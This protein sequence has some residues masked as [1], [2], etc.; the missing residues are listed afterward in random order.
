MAELLIMSGVTPH[1]QERLK[2][3][4]D[5]AFFADISPEIWLAET[6]SQVRFILT[7][8]P[9]GV[10]AD[11]LASLPNAEIISNVGVGYDGVDTAVATGRGIPVCHTPNVL[12]EEVA[13]TALMLYLACWRNFEAEMAH[14]RSGRW[15]ALGNLPLP[16]TADARTVGILGLG[17]IGKAIVAKLAPWSPEILYFGRSKQDVP[18][19]YF[20]DLTEMARACDT[21]INI[22]PGGAATQHLIN[23]EVMDAVGPAGN[24][25]NVGRGSTVDE[26]AL[27]A[28]LR[29]GSLGGAGLDVYE[30]EP[31][32]PQ[33]LRNASNVVLLPH[34]ASASIETRRAMGDLAVDNLIAWKKGE[35]LISPVPESASLI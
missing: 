29:E 28:A 2:A 35:A 26:T 23:R 8:G 30:S 17:R 19:R 11:V 13:T 31:F 4:F 25:I 7:D 24:L 6:G 5:L 16:R 9:T 15:E 20:D 3:E 27:I 34:V 10:P 22:A 1:M 21:L 33:A 32:I 12:N 14:A 18:Y